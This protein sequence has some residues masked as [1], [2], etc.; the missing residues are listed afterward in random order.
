MG[1]ISLIN[2]IMNKST[3]ILISIFLL[4][5]IGFIGLAVFKATPPEPEQPT[6]TD[7]L[8][9]GRIGY[10]IGL[11]RAFDPEGKDLIYTIVGQKTPGQ[12]YID[13]FNGTVGATRQGYYNLTKE[14]HSWIV[15]NVSDGE[16]SDQDTIDINYS[17]QSISFAQR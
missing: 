16:Y 3:K 9:R 15:V 13:A 2:M 17:R 11:I 5:I 8:K 12:F 6:E 14:K 1:S 4:F 7:N 10:Q